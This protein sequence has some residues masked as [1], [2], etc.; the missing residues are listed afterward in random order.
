M[1]NP[2]SAIVMR[3]LTNLLVF[4]TFGMIIHVRIPEIY[5]KCTAL[6]DVA[7]IAI[8]L[9][10]GFYLYMATWKYGERDRNLVKYNR[11]T[12][13]PKRGFVAGAIAA[14]MPLILLVIL[15]ISNF[16]YVKVLYITVVI[17]V[18]LITGLG[19][20]NG[21]K[22]KTIGINIIYKNTKAR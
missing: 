2:F 15:T 9:L 13:Q 7:S 20:L 8:I 5:P 16:S 3:L 4:V 22:L 1:K 18:P 10:G 17:L 6:L 19:Y 21:H 11:L 12:Y 14:A